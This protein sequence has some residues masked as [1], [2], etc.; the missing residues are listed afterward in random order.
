MILKDVDSK[1]LFPINHKNKLEYNV[2]KNDIDSTIST[3]DVYGT[4]KIKGELPIGSFSRKNGIFIP[5]P[6]YLDENLDLIDS[7]WIFVKGSWLGNNWIDYWVPVLPSFIK[8]NGDKNKMY[9]ENG[10]YWIYD[11]DKGKLFCKIFR[12]V[13]EKVEL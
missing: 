11:N 6:S 1:N 5:I 12:L 13:L 10:G 8:Q 3:G 4:N 2:D 9:Y 7:H